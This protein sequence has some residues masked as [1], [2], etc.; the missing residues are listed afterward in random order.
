MP[1]R[2]REVAV[3]FDRPSEEILSLSNSEFIPALASERGCGLMV[4]APGIDILR[5]LTPDYGDLCLG[6]RRLQFD[7]YSACDVVL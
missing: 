4:A 6:E 3:E 5:T 1:A 7:N 2:K